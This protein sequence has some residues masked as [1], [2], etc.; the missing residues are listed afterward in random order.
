[1]DIIPLV[2]GLDQH[3]FTREVGEDAQLDLGI[4][5]ADQLPAFLGQEGLADAPTEL[6][7][8]RNVLEVGVAAGEPASGRDGLVEVRMHPAGFRLDQKRQGFDV[9]AAQF[10]EGAVLQQQWHYGMVGFQFFEHRCIGTPTGFG[11]AG[12]LA[13]QLEGVEKQLSQLF[14]GSQV[15]L[16]S[17]SLVGVALE[18]G[19]ALAQFLAQLLQVRDIDADASGF[20]ARQHRFQR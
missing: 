14:G 16:A 12:F 13:I 4:V 3:L 11:F 18:L 17:G 6:G 7:A 5:G 1:M 15:E 19:Q 8:D 20:H 10:A 9:G 2:E